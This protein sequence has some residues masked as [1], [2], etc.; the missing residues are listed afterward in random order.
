MMVAILV[1]CY[2]LVLR[3]LDQ[4]NR[5]RD[6]VKAGITPVAGPAD[7]ATLKRQL[8]DMSQHLTSLENECRQLAA[9]AGGAQ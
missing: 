2:V 7:Y 8:A 5:E 4:K 6:R 9:R 1:I 3:Y